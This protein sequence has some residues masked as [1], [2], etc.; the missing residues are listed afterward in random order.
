MT[1]LERYFNQFRKNIIGI[2]AVIETP[3]GKKNLVY[4][5]WIAS[6]RLYAPIEHKIISQIGPLVGNTH[7][8]NT[9]TG[10]AMTEAYHDAQK[11]VKHHVPR[12]RLKAGISNQLAA[13]KG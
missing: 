13:I 12:L 5:D 9:T 4:A 6:G 8:E 11:I 7:S 1:E 3:Y 2:D 10:R